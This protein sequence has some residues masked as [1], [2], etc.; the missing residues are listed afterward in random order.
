MSWSVEFVGKVSQVVE[1]LTK[2]SEALEGQSKLEYDSALPHLV[3]VVKENFNNEGEEPSV[4]ISA[5]GHGWAVGDDQ[6]NRTLQCTL[7]RL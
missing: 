1:D 7:Q 6:K 5:Y 3:G 2:H 4:K